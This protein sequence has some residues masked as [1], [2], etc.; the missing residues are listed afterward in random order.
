MQNS[1][2]HGGLYLK[3][4]KDYIDLKALFLY[5]GNEKE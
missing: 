4:K 3:S 1:V 5:H 2:A